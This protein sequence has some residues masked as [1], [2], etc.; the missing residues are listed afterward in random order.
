MSLNRDLFAN[1]MH[2][3]CFVLQLSRSSLFA[4]EANTEVI[5]VLTLDAARNRSLV[6]APQKKPR[7]SGGS[8]V[9]VE[10]EEGAERLGVV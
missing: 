9:G 5:Q 10:L 2:K 1:Q 8:G 3:T 4:S 7:E 6:M